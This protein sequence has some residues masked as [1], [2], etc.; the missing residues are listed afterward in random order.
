MIS[1]VSDLGISLF[2]FLIEAELH[3]YYDQIK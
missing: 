1:I 2:D 3:H